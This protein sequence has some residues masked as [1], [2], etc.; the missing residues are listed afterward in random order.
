MEGVSGLGFHQNRNICEMDF[1]LK[2]RLL[3]GTRT[4]FY[5]TAT[6]DYYINFHQK[7]MKGIV[8]SKAVPPCI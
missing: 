2:G 5:A 6:T 4:S 3:T 1:V 7:D 8:A